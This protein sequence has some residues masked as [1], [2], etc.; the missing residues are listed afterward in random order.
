MSLPAAETQHG[1]GGAAHLVILAALVV[2][3]LVVLGVRWWRGRRD[4]Q[5]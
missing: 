3:V 2:I 5:R 4:A 1:P